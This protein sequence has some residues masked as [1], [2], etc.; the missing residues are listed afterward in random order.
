M[1]SRFTGEEMTRSLPDLL[2]GKTLK[3]SDD[4]VLIPDFDFSFADSDETESPANGPEAIQPPERIPVPSPEELRR[5]EAKR[6]AE[7]EKAKADAYRDALEEKRS[8]IS[9]CID[10][11]SQTMEGFQ[12][13][14][15][16]F[17][18]EYAGRLT[19]EIAEKIMLIKIEQDD[20]NLKPLVVQ[21]ISGVKNAEWF[22]VEL[23][24]R[25]TNL[26]TSLQEELKRSGSRGEVIAGDFPADT[27]RIETPEGVI[28][29]SV[30]EQIR[31]LK[32]AANP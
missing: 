21:A 3:E 16:A 28:D 11:V 12:R 17:L 4:K 5:T 22:S 14:H 29:A 18:A 27:C 7:L 1:K 30:R 25:L 9:G 10:K 6:K 32:R 31:N 2:K 13:A 23:S 19:V 24:D 20:E 15:D 8:Q 26:I